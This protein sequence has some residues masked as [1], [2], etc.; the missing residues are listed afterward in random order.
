[1]KATVVAPV[2]PVPVRVTTVPTGPEAGVKLV[3]LGAEI[4]EKRARCGRK[5]SPMEL[6]CPPI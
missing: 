1:M 2:K 3:M 6:N 5:T 4:G